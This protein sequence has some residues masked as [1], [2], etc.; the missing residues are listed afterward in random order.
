YS[1]VRYDRRT[2]QFSS[3]VTI[4]NVSGKLLEGPVWLKIKNL[5]PAGAVLI[6][7]DGMHFDEPYLI[8]LGEEEQW[9]PGKALPSKTLYF[10]NP[11]KQRITF[12]DQ[13]LAVVPEEGS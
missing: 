6:N 2:G 3:S 7:A 10:T 8:M 13:V 11:V 9:L 12:D 1:G 4:T 5:Q